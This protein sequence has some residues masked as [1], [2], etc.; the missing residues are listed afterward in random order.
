M[1]MFFSY[2]ERLRG[3]KSYYRGSTTGNIQSESPRVRESESEE[4]KLPSAV[5]KI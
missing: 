1:K 2:V 5:L 4:S 3:M